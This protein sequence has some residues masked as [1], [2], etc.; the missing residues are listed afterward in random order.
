MRPT[1]DG[2]LAGH[3]QLFRD[4]RRRTVRLGRFGLAPLLRGRGLATPMA[5]IAARMAFIGDAEVHR[6]ELHVYTGNL[7]A[8]AAYRRAGFTL[9]GVMREDL[10]VTVS[11]RTELWST[12]VMSLL[13]PEW[14]ARVLAGCG[15]GPGAAS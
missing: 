12:G 14:E 15:A 8:Q 5:Q 13:R 9:E 3:F 7:A 1:L 11:G 4:E 2:A 6:M 10:P